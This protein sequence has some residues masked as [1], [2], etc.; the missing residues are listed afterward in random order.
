MRLIQ[1]D[2]SGPIQLITNMQM[3]A[4]ARGQVE[5]IVSDWNCSAITESQFFSGFLLEALEAS[6]HASF[7]TTFQL[8]H[9]AT[10]VV[11]VLIT[12][13]TLPTMVM[14][15]KTSSRGKGGSG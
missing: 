9:P 2:S 1:F 14:M 13:K 8:Y 11:T 10:L 6:I 12:T 7:C 4:D 5:R 15:I 3:R